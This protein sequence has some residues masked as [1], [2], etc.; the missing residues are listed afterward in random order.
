MKVIKRASNDIELGEAHGGAGTRKVFANHEHLKST[1]FEAMTHGYMPAG[2]FY[3]WHDH[4]DIEEI[5][6]AVKG[7]GF[8]YDDEGKYPYEPGD[9][10]I[11]PANTMH[12]IDN[13][14]TEQNE[15]IFV[16]VKI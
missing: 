11:F 9:V 13:P 10:F 4:K 3:D 8:V 14:T 2:K 15:M 6:V 12:K 1:H 7:T 16:R 5:M